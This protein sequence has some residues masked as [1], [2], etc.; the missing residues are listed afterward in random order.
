MQAEYTNI[1]NQIHDKLSTYYPSTTHLEIEL[2]ELKNTLIASVED[3]RDAGN[4]TIQ[5]LMDDLRYYIDILKNYIPGKLGYT[6]KFEEEISGKISELDYFAW[7]DYN[8]N[9]EIYKTYSGSASGYEPF[10]NHKNTT[11]SSYQIHPF[12]WKFINTKKVKDILSRTINS[13]FNDRLEAR[14]IAGNID[15]MIGKFGEVINIW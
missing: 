13:F 3:L 4:Q 2:E 1:G 7:S 10:Y 8:D 5:E 9:Y 15:N 14:N 6:T 11:H 12:L